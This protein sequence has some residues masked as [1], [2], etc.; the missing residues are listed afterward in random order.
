[1]AA[2]LDHLLALVSF[3]LGGI[4]LANLSDAHFESIPKSI[5][6]LS[7]CVLYLVYY[8]VFEGLFST[9]PGKAFFGLR[10]LRLN[11]K[12]GTWRC[13]LI[14]TGTRLLEVNPL[15]LGGIPA[16]IAWCHPTR[17][18]I[19]GGVDFKRS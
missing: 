4:G 18:T 17:V 12:R 2:V 13:A 16:A 3:T 6:G 15:L 5:V 10:V 14:R 9:T 1:M 19:L 7:G 8:L 11:G